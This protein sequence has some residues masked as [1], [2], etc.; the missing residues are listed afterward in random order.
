[1]EDALAEAVAVVEAGA[2]VE[3]AV[4]AEMKEDAGL[5]RS[6]SGLASEVEC[7]VDIG[8]SSTEE[9]TGRMDALSRLDSR[10]RRPPPQ[11]PP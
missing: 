4:D 8:A 9:P 1:M 2:A 3:A 6:E 5:L 10:A 7:L 11:P